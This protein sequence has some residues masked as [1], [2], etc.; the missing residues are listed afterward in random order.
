MKQIDYSKISDIFEKGDF[1]I[2]SK[3]NIQ[4]LFNDKKVIFGTVVRSIL[5]YELLKQSQKNKFKEQFEKIEPNIKFK[6]YSKYYSLLSSIGKVDINHISPTISD[7]GYKKVIQSLNTLL[8][9][10][11]SIELYENCILIYNY[12]SFIE[13]IYPLDR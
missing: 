5:N 3:E 6:Y 11:I 8:E 7:I 1:E 9:Y 12:I 13:E 4:S 2:Y 10:F